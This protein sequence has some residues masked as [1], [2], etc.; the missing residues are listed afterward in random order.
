MNKLFKVIFCVL[1]IISSQVTLSGIMERHAFEL[2]VETNLKAKVL[3]QIIIGNGIVVNSSDCDNILLFLYEGKLKIYANV[4]LEDLIQMQKEF[5]SIDKYND[6]SGI[7]YDL[8]DPLFHVPM[9]DFKEIYYYNAK[10]CLINVEKSIALRDC[11]IESPYIILKSREIEAESW[12]INTQSIEIQS[13]TSDS[14]LS[15]I[16]F[17]LKDKADFQPVIMGIADFDDNFAML[18]C[19]SVSKIEVQ[20]LQESFYLNADSIYFN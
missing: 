15:S 2:H 1:S 3:P 9:V 18:I 4:E 7:Y 10:D 16:K 13:N 20:C 5:D 19:S 6:P 8:N 14:L 12:L 17:T 11:I